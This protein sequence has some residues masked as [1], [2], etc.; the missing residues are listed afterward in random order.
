LDGALIGL[1]RSGD[2][3]TPKQYAFTMSATRVTKT[4][5]RLQLERMI[6]FKIT[7]YLES[8]QGC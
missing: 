3:Q 6:N 4:N 7:E 8:A 5:S 2:A 1:Q